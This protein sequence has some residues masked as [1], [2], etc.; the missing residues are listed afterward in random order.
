V[1]AVS[2]LVE[3]FFRNDDAVGE[4]AISSSKLAVSSL[5]LLVLV[6]V[7]GRMV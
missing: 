7:A 4:A 3:S 1:A 5:E 2:P 6:L